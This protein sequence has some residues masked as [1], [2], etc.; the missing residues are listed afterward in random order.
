MSI[1]STLVTGLA[2]PITNLVSEFVE[3]KDKT[4]E[5]EGKIKTLLEQNAAQIE[6]KAADVIIAE[7]QG[8]SWLQRSWRP[9]TIL[10]FLF[11]VFWN[12]VVV[13]IVWAMGYPLPTLEA[14]SAVP[15]QVWQIILLGLSGYVGGRSF[16][17]I[18]KNW[19][20]GMKHR[21]K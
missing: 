12:A 4:R 13:P 21:G 3:D 15:P 11:I 2:A 20:E 8:E 5:I 14:M 19:A 17:K 9:M 16:E 7:A 10:F 6:Q 1:V 18:S